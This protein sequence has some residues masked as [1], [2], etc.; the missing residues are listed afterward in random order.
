M[1][2]QFLGMVCQLCGVLG[3][4]LTVCQF[5]GLGAVN[6]RSQ[7]SIGFIRLSVQTIKTGFGGRG[8]IFQSI[9]PSAFS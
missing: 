6:F 9:K 4:Q 5:C 2:C 1:V 7:R 8:A 3:N